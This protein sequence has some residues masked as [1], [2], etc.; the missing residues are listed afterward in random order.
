[1]KLK[2]AFTSFTG[3]IFI[4]L[5]LLS[6]YFFPTDYSIYTD[7]L[8]TLGVS[9]IYYLK[10]TISL[11][12]FALA[13]SAVGIGVIIYSFS[14]PK[15]FYSK[16]IK[17]FAYIGAF[18]GIICGI[19]FAQVGV[20]PYNLSNELHFGVFAISLISF[21]LMYIFFAIA[22]ILDKKYPNGY[23]FFYF[24]VCCF[25][26]VYIGVMI[27]GTSNYMAKTQTYCLILM[28]EVLIIQPLGS[29]WYY[30]KYLKKL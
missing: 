21:L 3:I 7:F 15:L 1:M 20:T 24:I 11:I 28:V 25:I 26:F 22:I 12:L 30:N 13:V 29:L 9:E 14:F 8:S 10:N 19:T 6:I 4:T 2:F 17:I 23:A 16:R 18:W 27:W 5:I